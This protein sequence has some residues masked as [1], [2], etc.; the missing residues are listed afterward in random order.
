MNICN[1]LYLIIFNIKG[2]R[3]IRIHEQL[4][5]QS[6]DFTPPVNTN[7]YT[8]SHVYLPQQNINVQQ[9]NNI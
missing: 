9:N 5:K 6:N 7:N 1:S 8:I 4:N 2:M 3:K